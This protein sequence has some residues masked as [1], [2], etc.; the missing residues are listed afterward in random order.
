MAIGPASALRI[1]DGLAAR[2]AL[3]GHYLLPSVRGELLGRLG[4]VTEARRELEEAA[5]L[6]GNERER[7]VLLGKAAALEGRA[8]PQD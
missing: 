2:R 7:A 8:P 5:R 3:S 1:V 4:R 6:T